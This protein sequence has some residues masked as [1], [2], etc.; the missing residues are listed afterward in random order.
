MAGHSNTGSVTKPWVWAMLLLIMALG[1][2]LRLLAIGES[3]YYDEV[4]SLECMDA[5]SFA[6]FWRLQEANDP[7]TSLAPVYFSLLYAWGRIT[8]L[9]LVDARVFSLL[10]GIL[11]IPILF[12]VTR[13]LFGLQA[14]LLAALFLAL[15]I[16]HVYYALEVRMYALTIFLSAL[17]VYTFLR[18]LDR[19]VLDGG[20]WK[21]W[22]LHGGIGILLVWTHLFASLLLLAQGLFLL[23]FRR[24]DPRLLLI[25]TAM[26]LCL[27]IAL[28]TWI[29][30]MWP[31]GVDPIAS[32]FTTPRLSGLANAF[33]VLAGGRFTNWDPSS[34]FPGQVS[35][36]RVLALV[37]YALAAWLCLRAYGRRHAVSVSQEHSAPSTP[38]EATGLMFFWV[39]IPLAVLFAFSVL[40]R[41][42]FV[43]RYALPSSLALFALA[44]GAISALEPRSRRVLAA[45]II[46]FLFVYQLLAL[47]D[48]MRPDYKALAQHLQV[49]SAPEDT[50]LTLK[51]YNASS[52]LFNSNL[53]EDRIE[54]VTAIANVY[55]RCLE[56]AEEGH[57]AWV[58]LWR[59][60]KLDEFE[61][62]LS[63]QALA[64]TA[65][66]FGGLPPM[67]LYRIHREKESA[68]ASDRPF[69][70][71]AGIAKH[72][73]PA[74]NPGILGGNAA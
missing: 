13:R 41:P 51:D 11:T 64:F 67:Y 40:I 74:A 9:S 68:E 72:L 46:V 16:L 42:Y 21:W 28:A 39:T 5:P 55:Q 48:P 62:Y 7:P 37:L 36:D 47:K 10:F 3:A 15:S 45:T 54:G 12:L 35:L 34:R 33:I 24:K 20:H 57:V 32:W 29:R 17:S 23:V 4:W 58:V 6:E 59:W 44:G 49:H 65:E 19:S 43:F 70:Q 2:G 52:L 18:L 56:T 25:W 53:P 69:L 71:P 73:N 30:L 61:A 50:I 27:F 31:S 1:L 8:G 38:L 26:H 60:E 63:S 66:T 22:L 14:G